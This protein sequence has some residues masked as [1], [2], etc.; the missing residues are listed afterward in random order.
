MYP[1]DRAQ[2]MLSTDNTT[3]MVLP[4][5]EN[6]KQLHF[7]SDPSVSEIAGAIMGVTAPTDNVTHAFSESRMRSGALMDLSSLQLA[8]FRE[9]DANAI[10]L[11]QAI[12][13]I[14]SVRSNF[15]METMEQEMIS[16]MT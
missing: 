4:Q 16:G 12:Q 7:T 15:M 3:G 2:G 14:F 13:Q 5:I 9:F 11:A 10:G 6:F 8:E 1:V